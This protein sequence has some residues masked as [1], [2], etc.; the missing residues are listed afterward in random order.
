MP[1]VVSVELTI[2]LPRERAEHTA[3][4]VRGGGGGGVDETSNIRILSG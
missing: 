4:C 3:A 2:P 1:G